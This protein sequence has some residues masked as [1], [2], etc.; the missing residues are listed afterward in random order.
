MRPRCADRLRAGP[1]SIVLVARLLLAAIFVVAGVG[2][3]ARRDRTEATLAKFGVGAALRRPLAIALPLAELAIALGLLPAA[4]A[5]WA[6]LGAFLLLA[7]FTVGVARVLRSGEE[8]ECN[9]FGALAPSHVSRWTLARNVA[10][11]ALAGFVA[12]AG[13]SEPGPGALAWIGDL[14]ATAAVGILAGLALLAAA[15][16]L[17]FS[18]QLMKQNGRL[19]A[20]LAA[21]AADGPGASGGGAPRGLPVGELTPGFALPTLDGDVVELD[22]LLDDGRGLILF[23]SDPGCGACEPLLAEVARL[24]RDPLADPRPVVISLGEPAAV[25][26]K[27]AQHEL[28]PVLLLDDF[29]RARALGINGFPGA[30]VLDREGRVAGEPAVGSTAVAPLLAASAEP[31]RLVQVGGSG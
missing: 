3:L 1:F 23:F 24:Q 19:V 14:D 17:A 25:A 12:V 5:P 30:L 28:G 22:E 21:V 2:K 10:L 20:E 7:A 13:W 26:A 11:M 16:N 29:E 8:V 27:A 31:L 6:G 9:C 18:W 4:T 15:V